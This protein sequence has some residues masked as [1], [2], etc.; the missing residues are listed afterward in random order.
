MRAG[1]P[2]AIGQGARTDMRLWMVMI[3]AIGAWGQEPERLVLKS[4]TVLEC[5]SMKRIGDWLVVH[6]AEGFD[7]EATQGMPRKFKVAVDK[8]DWPATQAHNPSAQTEPGPQNVPPINAA[9]PATRVP[10]AEQPKTEALPARVSSID[11]TPPISQPS[12]VTSEE[13]GQSPVVTPSNPEFHRRLHGWGTEMTELFSLT[14]GVYRV[15]MKP[16][17]SAGFSV[18]LVERDGKSVFLLANE[19]QDFS[20]F[21]VAR[22]EVVGDYLLSVQADGAWE[23]AI[24]KTGE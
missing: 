8:V 24:T 23:I 7:I 11:A 2:E 6:L 14:A 10:A 21:K 3:I 15:D 16:D 19:N 9:P 4:G 1:T 20:A 18:M 22:I 13:T 17:T 5:Q 12:S